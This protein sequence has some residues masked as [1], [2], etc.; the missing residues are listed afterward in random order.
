MA[1]QAV[2]VTLEQVTCGATEQ[3]KV[4]GVVFGL[5]DGFYRKAREQGL[6]FCCPRGHW[7]NYGKSD[8]EELREQIVGLE[9]DLTRS[10]QSLDDEQREHRVTEDSRRRILVRVHSGVCPHCKRSFQNLRRHMTSKHA[11]TATA[12][13]PAVHKQWRHPGVEPSV[14]A[15]CWRRVPTVRTAWRWSAVTCR[16]CLQHQPEAAAER[17]TA[18]PAS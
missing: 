7:V 2:M 18:A 8:N 15:R 10:R 5:S 3:R 12:P 17:L 13:Q 9:R 4:C 16:D 11:E 1:R 14:R 6:S